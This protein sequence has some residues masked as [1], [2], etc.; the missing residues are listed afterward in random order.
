MSAAVAEVRDVADR[1]R[2]P[3]SCEELDDELVTAIGMLF[4]G[5]RSRF[6]AFVTESVS[7]DEA[8]CTSVVLA[9][10]LV[11]AIT[12]VAAATGEDYF[13]VWARQCQFHANEVCDLNSL[14]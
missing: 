5:D 3:K 8:V 9:E 12:M 14:D 10:K 2:N 11:T 4:M 6:D 7:R 13:E 1:Y